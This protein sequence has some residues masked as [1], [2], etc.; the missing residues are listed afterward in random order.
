MSHDS[1]GPTISS[2]TLYFVDCKS[3]DGRSELFFDLNER[4]IPKLQNYTNF[5]LVL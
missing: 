3:A 1:T 4:Y 5:A 2:E